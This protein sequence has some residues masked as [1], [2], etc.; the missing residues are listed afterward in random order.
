MVIEEKFVT[1]YNVPPLQAV[2]IFIQ[3]LIKKIYILVFMGFFFLFS[4]SVGKVK[5]FF[6]FNAVAICLR[7]KPIY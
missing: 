4:R 7:T 3:V 5:Q 6:T 2:G 1:K